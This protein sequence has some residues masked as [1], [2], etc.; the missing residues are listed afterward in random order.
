M[1]VFWILKVGS[2]ILDQNRGLIRNHMSSMKRLK[3]GM[4]A[5]LVV[6]GAMLG[7][8]RGA[9]QR[10]LPVAGDDAVPGRAAGVRVAL[11]ALETERSPAETVV[12]HRLHFQP[13]ERG[14]AVLDEHRDILRLIREQDAEAARRAMRNH[15]ER[16]RIRMIGYGGDS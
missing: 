9:A 2:S 8:M 13:R 14:R 12:R 3:T 11:D 4:F 16:A 1:K 10:V 5:V 15:L 6:A 7:Q